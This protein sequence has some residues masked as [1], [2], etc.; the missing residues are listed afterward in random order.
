M[1][2]FVPVHELTIQMDA[3]GNVQVSG[4]IDNRASCYLMLE[5]ARDAVK[6]HNDK[7]AD[8]PKIEIPQFVP[9]ADA[10]GPGING[11]PPLRKL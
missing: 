2:G 5:M 1:A 3:L 6:D 8:G 10:A 7:K 9:P 4:P 11:R